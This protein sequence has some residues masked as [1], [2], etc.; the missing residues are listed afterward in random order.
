MSALYQFEL[1]VCEV[2]FKDISNFIDW[3]NF[4][5]FFQL[6]D[7]SGSID[8]TQLDYFLFSGFLKH[9]LHT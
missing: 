7:I 5:Y 4:D 9:F 3:T 2:F 8:W 1:C 6:L